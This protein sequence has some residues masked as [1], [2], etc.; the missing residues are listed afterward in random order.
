MKII[1]SILIISLI[2]ISCGKKFADT[3]KGCVT[4][5]ILASE[6]HDMNKLWNL[7]GKDA[8]AF[9]NDLG[10]KMRKSGRGA[11]ENE[12]NRIKTFRNISKDYSMKKDKDNTNDVVLITSGGAE[13]KIELEEVDGSFKIK[14]SNSVKS[15]FN[16]I[17]SQ[18]NNQNTY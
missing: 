3:P 1:Y 9:Y 15:I 12:L 16:V 5:F 2:F 10:E 11:L 14:N 7:L 8:Q 4:E 13:F 18:E 6:Q 17:T